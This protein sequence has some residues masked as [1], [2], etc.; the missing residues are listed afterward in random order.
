MNHVES[1]RS[2]RVEGVVQ[3]PDAS[4]LARLARHRIAAGEL[5]IRG[6]LALTEDGQ[7]IGRIHDVI[8]DMRSLLVAYVEIVL[9]ARF[10]NEDETKERHVVVP[11]ACARVAA[12]RMHVNIRG[13]SSE[14]FVCAPRFGERRI[15]EAEDRALRAFFLRRADGTRTQPLANDATR[16]LVR[17]QALFWGARRHGRRLQAYLRRP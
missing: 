3:Q 17:E 12:Q 1:T 9:D 5:D 11:I 4:R 8:V 2:A 14:E 10:A 13:T 15:G 6:W 16:Q 7:R